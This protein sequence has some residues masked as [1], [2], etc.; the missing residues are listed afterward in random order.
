[1][2]LCVV[3]LPNVP[4]DWLNLIRFGV[5]GVLIAI[6]ARFTGTS[7][8]G[9]DRP[10]LLLRGITG[11]T[12]SLVYF[13]ALR[14]GTPLSV[15]TLL[16]YTYPVFAVGVAW[17]ILR[18]KIERWEWF[19]FLLAFLGVYLVLDFSGPWRGRAAG[20]ML[21]LGAGFLTS[22]TVVLVRKL[23]ARESSLVIYF[24]SC[25]AGVVISLTALRQGI[26]SVNSLRDLALLVVFVAT[27]FAG[28]TLW[29]YGLKY[30][31]APIGGTLSMVEVAFASVW[32]ALI[33]GQKLT[34]NFYIGA[35]LLAV[36]VAL[37][38][39]DLTFLS[40]LRRTNISKGGL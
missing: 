33:L 5:G 12:G 15:A 37:L 3:L 11:V 14:L 28:Q 35:A 16:A 23:R 13:S 9:H 39:L 2:D 24:Y 34:T 7:I 36:S 8:R 40:S 4:V 38:S 25:V 17:L 26:P 31:R 18:E 30:I 19:P 10:I 21:A 1:M 22:F 32:G 6:Y 27:G 29:N 20:Q